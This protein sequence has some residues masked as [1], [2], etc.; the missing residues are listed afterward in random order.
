M[1]V[2]SLLLSALLLAACGGP[3]STALLTPGAAD[4]ETELGATEDA[5]LSNSAATWFPMQ[6]GNVWTL[7]DGAGA[8]RVISFSDVGGGIAWLDGFGA[9]GQWAGTTSSAPN[10]LY[11]WDHTA[12]AWKA[13]LRFGYQYT[14]WTVGSGA[15][16]TF[17]ARRVATGVTVVTPAGT[18]RD[19]RTIGFTLQTQPNVRCAPPALAEVTFA[20][21]VG[22]V[23]WKTATGQRLLLKSAKVDGKA[24]PAV[25]ASASGS[26]RADKAAYVNQPNTIRCITTPCPSNEVTAVAKLTYTVR[27][28]SSAPI[29]WQ[30]SSGQ[31]YEVDVVSASGAVVRRWSD[32][33]AFTMA[34]TSFTL[35]AG[36]SKTFTIELDLKDKAGNQLS[37]TY[38]LKA[39]LAARNGQ[40]SAAAQTSVTV[41]V[42]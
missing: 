10:T 32:G 40:P 11:A 39:Y 38:A 42:N 12:Y 22:V 2:R 37:G 7:S 30:F 41:T 4:L 31:Q 17:T 16:N 20:P 5:L 1:H 14:S 25:V 23:A 29:T 27:N 24:Y 33:R 21:G 35:A 15:C 19:A 18:F 6:E 3:D 36:A 34:L 13:L 9:E 26:V 8:T 28:T